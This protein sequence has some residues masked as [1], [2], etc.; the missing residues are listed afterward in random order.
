MKKWEIKSDFNFE[1]TSN[2][3]ELINILLKNRGI[4]TKK[5]VD[6]YLNPNLDNFTAEGLEISKKDLSK[7]TRRIK[8]AI[9]QKEQ[10]IVFGDYDVDGV[11]GAAILWETLSSMG[12]VV[13]PYIP[14][15]VDEGYGL[16][17]KG[18]DNLLIQYPNTKLII[19]VDNGIVALEPVEHANSLGINVIVTDHHVKGEVLPK[20]YAIVHSTKVCG[21]AVAYFLSSQ[22]TDGTDKYLDLVSLATVADVMPLAGLNRSLLVKGLPFLRKTKRP[23]LRALY[24]IA[25]IKPEEIGVY[26][27]GHIIAPRLNASGRLVHAMESLRLVCTRNEE[28]AKKIANLLNETNHQRQLIT[29]DSFDHAKDNASLEHK[30]LFVHSDTYEPGIIGLIAGK[31]T[32]EYYKPS[33]VLSVGNDHSK[34]SARSVSGFNIIEFIRLHSSFLVDAGGHPMAAGFTVETSKLTD[35]QKAILKTAE[36][37]DQELLVRKIKIDCKLL[38]DA[39]NQK[40]FSEICKLS[41]FGNGNPEPVFLANEL[42]LESIRVVGKE[43]K[44]LKLKVKSKQSNLTMDGILFGYDKAMELKVG[45]KVDVAYSIS[46]N[47]WNGNRKLELKIKDLKKN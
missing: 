20:A 3:S 29:F 31:L 17:K 27:I 18:I 30:L 22:L 23:G 13:M 40:L 4:N 2:I 16:S 6:E 7:A 19:T 1:K 9:D 5:E 33:I 39:I 21:A 41:P 8:K 47:N 11:T 14:H 42:S 25:K 28:R 35:L 24:E 26:E 12:A 34:A 15:R 32:E 46:E 10:V 38:I 43:G 45:D 44:H 37:I 36:A